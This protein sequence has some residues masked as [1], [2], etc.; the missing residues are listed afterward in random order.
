MLQ[1]NGKTSTAEYIRPNILWEEWEGI[2]PYL[3]R[4]PTGALEYRI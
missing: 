1:G 3:C 2:L 4:Q